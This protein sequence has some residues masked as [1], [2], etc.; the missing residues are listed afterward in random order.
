MYTE[1]DIHKVRPLTVDEVKA[2]PQHHDEPDTEIKKVRPYGKTLLI[3]GALGAGVLAAAVAIK[4]VRAASTIAAL[5]GMA[6][7]PRR[8][9]DITYE[10]ISTVAL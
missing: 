7:Q 4:H 8:T 9:I 10:T 3:A 5:R 6:E 1:D 2:L